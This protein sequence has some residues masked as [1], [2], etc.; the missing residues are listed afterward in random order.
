MAPDWNDWYD[1][2]AFSG[3]AGRY[4]TPH[5]KIEVDLVDDLHGPRVQ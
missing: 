3:S 4:L 2:A 1:V 5:L